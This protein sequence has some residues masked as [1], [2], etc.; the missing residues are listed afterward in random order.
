MHSCESRHTLTEVR[1]HVW[2]SDR[3]TPYLLGGQPPG[4]RNCQRSESMWADFCAYRKN[5][6]VCPEW[7]QSSL[8]EDMGRRAGYEEALTMTPCDFW[9]LIQGRTLWISGDSTYLS[10][11]K[12]RLWRHTVHASSTSMHATTAL[13][14]S[15]YIQASMTQVTQHGSRYKGP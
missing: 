3:I 15:W 14:A 1:N 2:E 9:P 8:Q 6:P 11:F 5:G 13:H 12:A 10:F 7:L 4:C